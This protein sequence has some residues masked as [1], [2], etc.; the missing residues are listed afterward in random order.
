[1]KVEHE[2]S[3]LQHPA[4][5][6]YHYDLFRS[7]AAQS[8]LP[9]LREAMKGDRITIRFENGYGVT[10]KAVSPDENGGIFEMLILRFHGAGVNDYRTAQY[11]PLPEYNRGPWEEIISLS[12]R[13]AI[14]PKVGQP[15]NPGE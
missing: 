13:I 9:R 4:F 7:T 12:R 5:P 1:M 14:F 2:M 15:I 8:A 3:D 10:I 11:I 6:S